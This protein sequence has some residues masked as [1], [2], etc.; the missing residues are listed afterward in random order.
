[1]DC[2]L[3]FRASAWG[4]P[5]STNRAKSRPVVDEAPPDPRREELA[6]RIARSDGK[7]L[8]LSRMGLDWGI[9]DVGQWDEILRLAEL[10]T[11]DLGH[12]RI[13]M[14]PFPGGAFPHLARL[15]LSHNDLQYWGT[16]RQF[17]LT[18]LDFPALVDLDLSANRMG[19]VLIPRSTVWRHSIHT[20]RLSD[21]GFP[22]W[23]DSY[24]P[25]TIRVE[26]APLPSLRVLSLGDN[27]L[28]HVPKLGWARAVEELD[29][30]GNPLRCN[31]HLLLDL[32]KL[33]VLDL[34]RTGMV[35]V[36]SSLFRM[37]ALTLL[38]LRANRLPP[39]TV[40]RLQRALPRTKVLW[41]PY[42]D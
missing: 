12:N 14:I 7:R 20:L 21:N 28:R 36:P 41:D 27:Q 37:K 33:R 32:P 19:W 35:H 3:P 17:P 10:S 1:L 26:S 4:A 38:D 40:R 15:D 16:S 24:V 5:W 9:W 8:S 18:R 39:S 2:S 30:G 34:S 29:L 11:L 23:L 31:H 25:R 42:D 22:E 13:D 6:R